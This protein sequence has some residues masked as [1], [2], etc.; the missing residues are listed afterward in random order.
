LRKPTL[1]CPQRG[2]V[3]WAGKKVHRKIH[4]IYF[5][6]GTIPLKMRQLMDMS[7]VEST[8]LIAPPLAFP[9]ALGKL[10][11]RF[12]RYAEEM[13]QRAAGGRGDQFIEF[14]LDALAKPCALA[15]CRVHAGHRELSA[16]ATCRRNSLA[17]TSLDPVGGAGRAPEAAE[18]G[19]SIVDSKWNRPRGQILATGEV[20]RRT[21]GGGARC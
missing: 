19:C 21:P 2:R 12:V 13:W 20:S 10:C 5:A 11:A 3:G 17:V 6:S 16:I 4:I 7:R 15:G 1:G 14:R 18:A 8:R 9:G